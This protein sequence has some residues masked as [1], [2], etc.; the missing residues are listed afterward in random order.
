MR[1]YHSYDDLLKKNRDWVKNKKDE[2]PRFFKRLSVGQRPPYLI[3][4]CADSRIPIDTF[5]QVEPGE[6]FVHRNIANLISVTDMNFL[7]VLEYAV[8]NLHVEHIIICGHTHCGGIAAAYKSQCEGLVHNWTTPIK[9]LIADHKLLLNK[10][11]S[12]EKRLD[13]ISELNVISQVK[14]LFKISVIRKKIKSGHYPKIHGW[15]LDLEDGHI[16]IVRLPMETWKKTGI[17]PV[18][19]CQKTPSSKP[20]DPAHRQLEYNRRPILRPHMASEIRSSQTEKQ[21]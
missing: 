9:D 5:M 13:K 8:N 16:Q 21:H 18:N 14:N 7:S 15:L 20:L 12:V 6:F 19:Y 10:I 17:V 1:K 3:L 4:G 11:T 2:D